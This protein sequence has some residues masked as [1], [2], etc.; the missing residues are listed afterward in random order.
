MGFG[1]G[2]PDPV[3]FMSGWSEK[4][5]YALAARIMTSSRKTRG[6]NKMPPVGTHGTSVAG[7]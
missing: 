7:S 5:S 1:P 4:R 6:E 3:F 2:V